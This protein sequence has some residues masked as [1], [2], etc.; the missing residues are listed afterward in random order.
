[1][2]RIKKCTCAR[3]KR[4]YVCQQPQA[5]CSVPLSVVRGASASGAE[6]AWP[7]AS[8]VAEPSTRP[9]TPSTS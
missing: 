4:K 6:V 8:G 1:M 3:P 2:V 7:P 5:P 9:G